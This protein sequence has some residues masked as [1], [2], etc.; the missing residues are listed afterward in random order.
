MKVLLV[1][2]DLRLGQNTLQLLPMNYCAAL[3]IK[4]ISTAKFI[5]KT[6]SVTNKNGIFC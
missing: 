3:L 2:D 1:E 6:S 4:V 5:M